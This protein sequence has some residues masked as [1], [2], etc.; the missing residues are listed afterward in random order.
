MCDGAPEKRE[1]LYMLKAGENV[2][3][4]IKERFEGIWISLWKEDLKEHG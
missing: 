2:Y 1:I 3:K 4:F